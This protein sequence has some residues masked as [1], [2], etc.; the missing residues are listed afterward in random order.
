[1]ASILAVPVAWFLSVVLAVFDALILLF[2]DGFRPLP[3]RSSSG[4]SA[5]WSAS[6]VLIDSTGNLP[7]FSFRPSVRRRTYY[8]LC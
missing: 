8:A 5:F 3:H 7:H 4:I 2:S 6:L 1:M